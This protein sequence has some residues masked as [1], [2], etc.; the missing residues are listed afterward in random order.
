[1][2]S[3]LVTG[4]AGY[5]GCHIVR[6]LREGGRAHVVLDDLTEGH[7][8][9]VPGSALEVGNV[10]DRETLSSVIRRHKVEWVIHM[11]ASS[12]VGESMTSPGKYWRNNLAASLI[13]LEVCHEAGVRGLVL[14]STAAVYGEPIRVPLEEDHPCAP[15]NV[16]GETK[17]AVERAI[18]SYHA[19]HGFRSICLRYFNA[20]GAAADGTL[21]ED[22]A[23]ETHLIPLVLG[24]AL[25]IRPPVTV[26]GT[27]YPTP[28][29]TGIRDYIHVEDLAEAHLLAL[30]ALESGAVERE[31]INLGGGEGRSVREVLE[32]AGQIAGKP[33]PAV[34]GPRRRGDPAVLVASSS[35]A[36]R[37][38]GWRPGRSD[39]HT[40]IESAWRWHSG[41]PRGYGE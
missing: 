38:L 1:M 32:L 22:H 19:A 6:A 28:D 16:Y 35:K 10:A 41:H 33:I 39:L 18:A 21:G 17:L 26:L 23:R 9:S 12:L 29:G 5:I 3:I 14:S 37:L 8:A 2:G 13:L 34:D 4:G 15:T 31:S 7:A 40:I 27:D 25:G 30:E 11:A 20:A 24:A 36:G